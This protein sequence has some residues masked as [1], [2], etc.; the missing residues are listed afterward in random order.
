MARSAAATGSV[1]ASC[2][3]GQ[4]CLR[5]RRARQT[6]GRNRLPDGTTVSPSRSDSIRQPRNSREQGAQYPYSATQD[7]S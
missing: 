7:I 2:T 5:A 3:L 1:S 4:Q 6:A